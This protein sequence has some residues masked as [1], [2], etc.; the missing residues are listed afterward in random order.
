[1][2]S[3]S[4]IFSQNKDVVRRWANEVTEAVNSKTL[5]T[6]YHALGALYLIRQHDR[7]AVIKLIQTYARSAKSPHAICML[8]RFC[9]KTMHEDPQVFF[10]FN[11]EPPH[12]MIIFL[13]SCAIEVIWLYTKLAE[14]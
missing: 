8:I 7:M 1:L 11:L 9:A 3:C 14:P 5:I 10:S 2:V 13:L 12:F 4:L 6:Q